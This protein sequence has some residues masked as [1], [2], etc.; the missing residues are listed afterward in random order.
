MKKNKK[1]YRSQKAHE[2][3]NRKWHSQGKTDK[4]RALGNYHGDCLNVQNNLGRV[5]TKSERKKIFSWWWKND[6]EKF[7]TPYPMIK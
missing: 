4:N 5:L 7:F 2:R 1:F 6:V 3:L